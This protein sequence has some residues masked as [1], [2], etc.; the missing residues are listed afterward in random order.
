MATIGDIGLAEPS[1]LTKRLAA[2]E[3][4]RNSTVQSQEVMVLGSPNSTGVLALAEVM[5]SAP[6]STVMGLAVRQVGPIAVT[7]STATDLLTAAVQSGTWNIGTVTTVTTVSAVTTVS[8]LAG[9]VTARNFTSSGGAVEGSTTTPPTGALGLHVRP[10]HPAL[11]T[12]NSTAGSDSVATLV[13]SQ[14]TTKAFV[15]AYTVNSTE[16]GPI[17]CGFYSGSTLVWPV[18]IWAEGGQIKDAQAVPHPSYLFAGS[19]G[20]ALT[21]NVAS[22]GAFRVAI[23]Y[24]TGA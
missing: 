17:Q 6:A 20:Q 23:T 8:S 13:S 3:I 22:T 11:T 21:F 4:T 18:T 12:F 2:V 10:L 9:A 14:A 1:T 19:T 16:A 7:N 5:G 24:W 15:S